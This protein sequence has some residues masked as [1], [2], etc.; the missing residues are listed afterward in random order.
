MESH[1]TSHPHPRQV[2]DPFVAVQ[3]PAGRAP[4]QPTAP[5]AGAKYRPPAGPLHVR[6]MSDVRPARPARPA[7]GVQGVQARPATVAPR[8][9]AAPAAKAVSPPVQPRQHVRAAATEAA[10]AVPVAKPTAQPSGRPWSFEEQETWRDRPGKVA[11]LAMAGLLL[12]GLS[13]FSLELGEIA[14]AAYA[15]VA[16]W[17]RWPSRQAFAIALGM[18]GGTVVTSLVPAWRTLAGNLA[19]YAFL[20]LCI[21]TVLMW[22]EMRRDARLGRPAKLSTRK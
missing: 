12:G 21:G 4:A 22:L 7:G 16:I 9:A 6:Y 18:F 8:Q 1:K 11:M 3:P 2:V 10:P 17:R 20:L 13:L 5:E 19:V 15:I 14:V